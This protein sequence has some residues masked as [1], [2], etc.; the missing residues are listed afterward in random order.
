MRRNRLLFATWLLLAASAPAYAQFVANF[1]VTNSGTTAYVINGANNPTL[2]WNISRAY[3]L[4]INAPPNHP[5]R[6]QT[7]AGIGGTPFA[8]CAPQ[9]LVTGLINCTAPAAAT[10]L[11]YQCQNHPA[12]NGQIRV[13]EPAAVP[14]TSR[15]G[16][17]LLIAA[18]LGAGMFLLRQRRQCA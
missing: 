15:L 9:D 11:F 17:S 3:I 14:A 10:T 5:F 4:Q 8:G 18:L 7:T 16:I 13:N 12:M 6:V 2:T 1:L